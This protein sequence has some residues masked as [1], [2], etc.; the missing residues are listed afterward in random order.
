MYEL[1]LILE[2]RERKQKSNIVDLDEILRACLKSGKVDQI[3]TILPKKQMLKFLNYHKSIRS[4][5][6]CVN[7]HEVDLNDVFELVVDL[8][9]SGKL[10]HDAPLPCAVEES[11]TKKAAHRIKDGREIE[12]NVV[13]HILDILIKMAEA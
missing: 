12:S 6:E 11:P 1:S 4:I 7:Y 13:T 2:D 9:I 10:S 3:K 8:Y 5:Q